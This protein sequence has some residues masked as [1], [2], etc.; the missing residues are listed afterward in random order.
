MARARGNEFE[1]AFQQLEEIVTA[2]ERKL[3]ELGEKEAALA[4]NL[5]LPIN[6][7]GTNVF[8][9]LRYPLR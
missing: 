6:S 4:T 9:R 7:A 5:T 1:K 2:V 3:Q 8:Y